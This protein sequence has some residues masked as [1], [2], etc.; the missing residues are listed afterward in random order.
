[1]SPS[2]LIV[3]KVPPPIGGV[4]IHNKRLMEGLNARNVPF[5]HLAISWGNMVRLPVMMMRHKVIHLQASSPL[6]RLVVAV[7]G[8]VLWRRTIIKI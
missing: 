1:M 7:L 4:T 6:L 8:V 5:T 3:A 2:L